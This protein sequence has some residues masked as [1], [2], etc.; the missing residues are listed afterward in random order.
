MPGLGGMP[1]LVPLGVLLECQGT[2]FEQGVMQ[3][4]SSCQVVTLA[5]AG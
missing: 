4:A 3:S 1:R 2:V 5:L